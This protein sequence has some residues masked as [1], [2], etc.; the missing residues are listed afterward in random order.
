MINANPW[1]VWEAI[2]KFADE[3]GAKKRPVIIVSNETSFVLVVKGTTHE[4]RKMFQGEHQIT[5]L[6]GTG[7]KQDTTVRC[8]ELY[9]L[10]EQDLH[11]KIGELS[12][13]DI[14]VIQT[15]IEHVRPP[16]VRFK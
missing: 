13:C 14:A 9:E 10:V 7:L 16:I 1:E 8:G 2:V 15:L 5:K 6:D 3:P 11:Q 12:I 4:P